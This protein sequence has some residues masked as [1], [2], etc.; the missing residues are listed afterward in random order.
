[1]PELVFSFR[2]RN[3]TVMPV[4]VADGRG[5][6][7]H[8]LVLEA[9]HQ[10][11]GRGVRIARAVGDHPALGLVLILQEKR[12]DRA[13]DQVPGAQRA[14]MRVERAE[15]K[16]QHDLA[17]RLRID[18][19]KHRGRAEVRLAAGPFQADE[20]GLPAATVH[21]IAKRPEAALGAGHRRDNGQQ[22]PCLHS[23]LVEPIP[24]TGRSSRRRWVWRRR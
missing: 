9:A 21:E 24:A 13:E 19:R 20:F 2:H 11:V 8:L 4:E 6:A 23:G 10:D 14:E 3:E 5:A 15:R 12:R 17:R 22:R 18:L 16:S 7:V 1:M